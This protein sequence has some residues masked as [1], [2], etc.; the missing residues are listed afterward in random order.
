MSALYAGMDLK[1]SIDP[2]YDVL[3]VNRFLLHPAIKPML[4][5][6]ALVPL[7]S[8]LWAIFADTLGPARPRL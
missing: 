3:G 6:L 2:A 8:L 5:A 7:A 1:S 4:L